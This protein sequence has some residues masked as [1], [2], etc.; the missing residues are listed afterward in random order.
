[1]AYYLAA[2]LSTVPEAQNMDSKKLQQ[3]LLAT[4]KVVI[5]FSAQ[6]YLELH[7]L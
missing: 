2:W 6:R 1:M 7:C 3:A 5:I 4:V